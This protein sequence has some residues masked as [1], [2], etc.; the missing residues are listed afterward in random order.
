MEEDDDALSE[1]GAG[2]VPLPGFGLAEASVN[3]FDQTTR[4]RGTD[5]DGGEGGRRTRRRL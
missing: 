4:K 3:A 5:D 2:G 1:S